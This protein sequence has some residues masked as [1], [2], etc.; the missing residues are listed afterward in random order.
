MKTAPTTS[1]TRK[2]APAPAPGDRKQET[3]LKLWVVLARAFDSVAKNVEAD[4][5]EYDLTGTEFGILE[6][7]YH[8]GP[9]LLGEIQRKILVTSGGITYLVDRLV[10]KGFV[11]REQCA[12]DR[13]AR[14][15]VLTPSG[16]ALIRKIFPV[17]AARIEQSLSGLTMAEQRE[18][19]ALLRKLGLAAAELSAERE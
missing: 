2:S 8:K 13:R 14:Y 9:M 6:A 7:L 1:R 10:A 18:A 16:Q 15:A 4:V 11:K 5:A 3:A 17:H 12:E 19:T